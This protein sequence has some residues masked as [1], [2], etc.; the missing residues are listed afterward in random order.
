[1][2]KAALSIPPAWPLR[3]WHEWALLMAVPL[4]LYSGSLDFGLLYYDDRLFYLQNPALMGGAPGGLLEV[5]RTVFFS[6]YQPLTQTTF[7][8]DLALGA[9]ERWWPARLQG[10][11]WCGAGAC[12]VRAWVHRLTGR[13]GLA[14]SV[15]LLCAAHPAAAPTALWLAERKNQLCFTFSF[16]ALERY[17]AA[18]LS[19]EGPAALRRGAAAWGLM[20]LALGSKVHA[21][22]LP[23]ALVLYELLLG[24]G[25]WKRRAAWVAPFAATAVLATALSLGFLRKDIEGELVGGGHLQ[26]LNSDGLVVLRYLKNTYAPLDLSLIYFVDELS[27]GDWRGWGAWALS[28]ALAGGAV[29]FSKERRLAALAWLTGGVFLFP[30][31]NALFYHP[32]F[33]ADHYLHWALPGWLLGTVLCVDARL[34][35]APRLARLRGPAVALATALLAFLSF[36]RMPLFGSRLAVFFHDTQTQ[37]ESALAWGHYTV[38]LMERQETEVKTATGKIALNTLEMRFSSRI[39]LMIRGLLMR[40]AALWLHR[41]GEPERAQELLA[42]E[43]ALLPES[44]TPLG[45]LTRA[46]FANY[47][48]QPLE[49]V[50]LLAET[51]NET[52]AKAAVMLRK[53]CRSGRKLPLELD[54]ILVLP[55]EL[56]DPFNS[57]SGKM[58]AIERLRALAEGHMLSGDLERAFDAAA[59]LVNLAPEHQPGRVVLGEV[60]RRLGLEDAA[61]RM[62]AYEPE[63]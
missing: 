35:H 6:E 53:D 43:C 41:G 7:W 5:W 30:A 33:M 20:L 31:L 26:A 32:L 3:P 19:A 1:M 46:Q 17:A 25:S 47:T 49:A 24:Q 27:A 52:H 56:F 29:Y 54:P 21:V 2:T 15:A 37:P 4:L 40:E 44:W 45:V 48:G 42:R 51:W 61:A 23:G 16:F 28:L 39:P 12:A 59:V 58:I 34:A 22:M 38:T 63:R 55:M 57:M 8:V 11:L 62:K 9:P 60:Y 14:L 13:R 10:L 50:K 18:R 36:A